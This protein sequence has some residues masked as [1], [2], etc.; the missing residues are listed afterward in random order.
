MKKIIALLMAMALLPSFT[1]FAENSR[2]IQS[3][4]F[5]SPSAS[6]DGDGTKE[7]PY[8]TIEQAQQKVRTMNTQMTGDIVVNLL[9][10]RYELSDTLEFTAK[11]SGSNHYDVIYRGSGDDT[12]L[13]GGKAVSGWKQGENGIWTVPVEADFVRELY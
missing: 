8:K 11:D 3:E 13:S 10:G 12:T 7:H 4:L 5:V 6:I 9:P 1:A 2:V